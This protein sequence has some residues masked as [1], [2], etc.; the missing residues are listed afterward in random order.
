MLTFTNDLLANGNSIVGLSKAVVSFRKAFNFI[1][2]FIAV[3]S[4]L[5]DNCANKKIVAKL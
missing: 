4:P 3:A 2:L 1:V 5:E